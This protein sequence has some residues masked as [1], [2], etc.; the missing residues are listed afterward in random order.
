MTPY[1]PRHDSR[2]RPSKNA[3]LALDPSAFEKGWSMDT[4]ATIE[5]VSVMV[6]QW[7]ATET[8]T[9]GRNSAAR[10]KTQG[11]LKARHTAL[12]EAVR[13]ASRLRQLRPE[14]DSARTTNHHTFRSRRT[15]CEPHLASG[16]ECSRDP[17]PRSGPTWSRRKLE[18]RKEMPN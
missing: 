11:I 16:R 12:R 5:L 2:P 6:D 1:A 18:R 7:L 17:F 4:N 14:P 10:P 9:C 3:Q 15:T 13:Q 8:A